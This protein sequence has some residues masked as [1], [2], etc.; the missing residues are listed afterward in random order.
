MEDH[1]PAG[2]TWFSHPF[3]GSSLSTA[4]FG[5]V[6]QAARRRRRLKLTLRFGSQSLLQIDFETGAIF[7]I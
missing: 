3:G 5:I 4:A 7:E 2:P 6:I 1:C